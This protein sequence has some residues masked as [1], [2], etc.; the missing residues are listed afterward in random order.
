MRY[1]ALTPRD[2][3]TA[4]EFFVTERPLAPGAYILGQGEQSPNVFI[5]ESPAALIMRIAPTLERIQRAGQEAL[6]FAAMDPG[7]REHMAER[8]TDG[9]IRRLSEDEAAWREEPDWLDKLRLV[10]EDA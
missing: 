5:A 7:R 6:G 3:E 10:A 9:L 2:Q 8:L 1:G 4:I